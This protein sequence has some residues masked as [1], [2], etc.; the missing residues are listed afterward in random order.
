MCLTSQ[1]LLSLF[2]FAVWVPFSAGVAYGA[3]ETTVS[4]HAGQHC[5]CLGLGFFAMGGWVSH[6]SVLSTRELQC[7]GILWDA[8]DRTPVSWV[9]VKGAL[10]LPQG[11]SHLVHDW[12][13]LW[14][15]SYLHTLSG[16]DT[17]IDTSC[18]F[19]H[20]SVMPRSHACEVEVTAP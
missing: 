18:C 19:P 5:T 10:A 3:R 6:L 4:C 2:C 9:Q 7:A 11:L 20:T 14:F 13:I 16:F 17:N 15:V 8:G 12:N 1:L